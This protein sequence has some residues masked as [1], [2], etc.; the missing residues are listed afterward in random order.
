MHVC[1]SLCPTCI[2][3]RLSLPLSYMYAC[4]SVPPSLLHVHMHVCPSLSPTCIH[5]RLSLPLDLVEFPGLFHHRLLLDALGLIPGRTHREREGRHRVNTHLHT[6]LHT[7]TPR[8][9]VPLHATHALCSGEPYALRHTHTRCAGFSSFSVV[10]L[11][12]SYRPKDRLRK[13]TKETD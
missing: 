1:P 2:H 9:Y 13:Q 6:H 11:C 7:H 12:D 4:T 5:A 3:A 10:S 8:L